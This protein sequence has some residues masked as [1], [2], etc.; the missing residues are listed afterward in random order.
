MDIKEFVNP[1]SMLT[2]GVAGAVVMAIANSLWVT[3]GL[4]QAWTGL[5]VS[6]LLGL[7][8]AGGMAAPMWQRTVYCVLNALV[9]FSMSIGSNSV[10]VKAVDAPTTPGPKTQLFELG[11][12]RADAQP[13]VQPREAAEITRQKE[14]L[15][16]RERDLL[17]REKAL[18]Q[19]IKEQEKPVQ[20]ERPRRF[21]E[22]WK[23]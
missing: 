9:I 2:P 8:V 6:L 16:R 19:K 10:G 7:L 18:E 14:E 5:L 23:F 22:Q 15:Q 17:E 13:R 20:Q 3:F 11:P 12:A 4:P 1:K 21:F